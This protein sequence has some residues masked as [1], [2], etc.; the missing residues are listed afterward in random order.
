VEGPHKGQIRRAVTLLSNG[1][2]KHK[3]KHPHGTAGRRVAPVER[4]QLSVD[5]ARPPKLGK[6]ADITRGGR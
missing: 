2:H 3:K 4:G 5:D 1:I 6:T